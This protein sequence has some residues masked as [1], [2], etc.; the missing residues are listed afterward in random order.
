MS[1]YLDTENFRPSWR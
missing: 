1:M